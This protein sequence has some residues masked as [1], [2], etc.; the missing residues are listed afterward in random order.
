LIFGVNR[1]EGRAEAKKKRVEFIQGRTKGKAMTTTQKL[2]SYETALEIFNMLIADRSAAL[3]LERAKQTPDKARIDALIREKVAL[4]LESNGMDL[5]DQRTIERV[6]AVHGGAIKAA[7][8]R[9]AGTSAVARTT[10]R[11]G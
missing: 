10:A 1:R 5:M 7:N 11:N 4:R 9:F 3:A 2:A 8:A 6:I